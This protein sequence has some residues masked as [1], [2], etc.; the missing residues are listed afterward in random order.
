M[1]WATGRTRAP[2]SGARRGDPFALLAEQQTGG[3]PEIR[4]LLMPT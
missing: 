1:A 2:V 4:H 3:Q